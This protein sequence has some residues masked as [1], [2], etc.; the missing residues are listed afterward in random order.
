MQRLAAMLQRRLMGTL[1]LAAFQQKEALPGVHFGDHGLVRV[2]SSVERGLGQH[3]SHGWYVYV[4]EHT[5]CGD[6]RVLE[7]LDALLAPESLGVACDDDDGQAQEGTEDLTPDKVVLL[8][9][10]RCRLLRVF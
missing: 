3:H 2:R 8:D 5:L 7:S 1:I 9:G 10:K 6:Q 4:E